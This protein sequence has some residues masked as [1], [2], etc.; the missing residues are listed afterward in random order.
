MAEITL[1][2][3]EPIDLGP[4]WPRSMPPLAARKEIE[5]RLVALGADPKGRFNG[6]HDRHTHKSTFWDIPRRGWKGNEQVKA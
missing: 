6:S 5:Q 2:P 4:D 3:F 1:S